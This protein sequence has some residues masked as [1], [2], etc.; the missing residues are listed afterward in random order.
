MFR[1]SIFP[2]VFTKNICQ[3][4]PDETLN[5]IEKEKE[6]IEN[7]YLIDQLEFLNGNYSDLLKNGDLNFNSVNEQLD[8]HLHRF[9][10]STTIFLATG[11]DWGDVGRLTYGVRT[12]WV[13][14][15]F[16]NRIVLSNYQAD[17]LLRH[18]AICMM[19]FVDTVDEL[20]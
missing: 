15:K 9:L 18:G 7:E 3:V 16:H 2:R 11:G 1:Y 14:T 4:L 6:K 19:Y 20:N 13:Q 12:V 8:I 17:I 5:L 10:M